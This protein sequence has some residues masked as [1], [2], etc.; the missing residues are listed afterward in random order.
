MIRTAVLADE[1]V[2]NDQ[3]IDAA[4]QKNTRTASRGLS[5]DLLA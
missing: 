3:R 1:E 5:Y 2:T 4:P